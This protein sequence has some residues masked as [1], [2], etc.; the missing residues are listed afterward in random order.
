MTTRIAAAGLLASMVVMLCGTTSVAQEDDSGVSGRLPAY[1]KDV[2]SEDQKKQIY[3]IQ[4]QFDKRLA[5]LERQYDELTEQVKKLRDDI[6]SIRFEERDAIEK[7][8]T[9]KQLAQVKQ[10][11]AEA[12][13]RLAQELLRAAEEAAKRAEELAAPE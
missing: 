6:D 9:P 10:R 5:A 1:Y 8:L 12:Q 2:V 11:Q 13:A 7:V 4:T 3:Q